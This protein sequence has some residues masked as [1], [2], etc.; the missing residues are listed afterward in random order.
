MGG[1]P[2]LMVDGG[3]RFLKGCRF[4]GACRAG[5]SSTTDRHVAI[6]AVLRRR[7][8]TEGIEEISSYCGKETRK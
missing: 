6:I 1:V 4:K 8:G 2:L 5:V 7:K 3:I